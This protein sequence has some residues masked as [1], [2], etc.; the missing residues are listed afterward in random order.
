MRSTDITKPEEIKQ[1]VDATIHVY[2][3]M[4]WEKSPQEVSD[5]TFQVVGYDEDNLQI[6]RI[7][8]RISEYV[9]PFPFFVRKLQEKMV[10]SVPNAAYSIAAGTQHGSSYGNSFGAPYYNQGVWDPRYSRDAAMDDAWYTVSV[11]VG[12]FT[13]QNQ[14]VTRDQHIG[15]EVA[16]YLYRAWQAEGEQFPAFRKVDG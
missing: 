6:D 12:S 2:R 5:D 1:Y 9:R 4:L 14:T 16:K 15:F 7:R 11:P 13:I 10:V 3:R 8:I